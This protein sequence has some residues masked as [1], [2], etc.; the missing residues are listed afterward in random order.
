MHRVSI[1]SEY[2]RHGVRAFYEGSGGRYRNPHE[3]VLRRVI[4]AAV[5]AW[6]PDLSSVLDL[7]CGSG[8]ATLALRRVGARAIDGIDPHTTAAYEARTGCPAE[9][10]S[11]EE[12]AAGALS[13]RRYSLI[14]CSFAL[15]LV[16]P[17]RLPALSFQLSRIADSLLVAT[18]HKRP[19]IDTTWGWSLEG[20]L[21]VERVRTRYYR[22]ATGS[23]SRAS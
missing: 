10:F 23:A 18:P 6:A 14:V 21:A 12:I 7:A 5:G 9:G 13:A 3:P 15:H 16:E 4:E 8:E 11:F 2:E 17:S 1:R 22:S 19:A 20:E